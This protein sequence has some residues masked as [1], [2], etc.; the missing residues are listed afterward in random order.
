MSNIKVRELDLLNVSASERAD[1]Q[2]ALEQSEDATV[3]HSLEWNQILREQFSLENRIMVAY[4][5]GV[6]SGAFPFCIVKGKGLRWCYSP[7]SKFETP[8]GGPVVAPGDCESLRALV[9]G[10]QKSSHALYYRLT[11]PPQ[12]NP[13][14]LDE[15]G[16]HLTVRTTAILD[17]SIGEEAL[18]RQL[19]TKTRNMVRKAQKAGVNV[20]EGQSSDVVEYY[21]MVES[22]FARVGYAGTLPSS[23]YHKV[24]DTLQPAG[25]ARMVVAEHEGKMIA[26]VI[27]LCYKKTIYYWHA[28][29]LAE[30]WNLAP[31]DLLQW[32][33]IKWACSKGYNSYDM[34]VVEPQ[35]WPGVAKFKLSFGARMTNFY[36]AVKEHQALALARRLKG[37]V[38]RRGRVSPPGATDSGQR[39]GNIEK[40]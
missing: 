35:R 8:Y 6:P 29:S 15:L 34:L 37:V 7:P 21:R 10:C 12:P 25:M 9:D 28:A 26:G 11:C 23:F 16:Y 38:P 13:P 20:R 19:G 30:S 40:S 1:L 24:I 22:T 31:N 5:D 4:K 36:S 32:E 2:K 18:W 17:M 27:L 14:A 33:I 3:F 39:D